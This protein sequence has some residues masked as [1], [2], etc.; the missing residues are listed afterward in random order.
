M[1]K[2]MRYRKRYDKKKGPK[3][4]SRN[5]SKDANAIVHQGYTVSKIEGVAHYLYS[6]AGMTRSQEW[7]LDS[8]ASTPMTGGEKL[9]CDWEPMKAVTVT[10]TVGDRF[11]DAAIGSATFSGMQGTVTFTG[12]LFVPGQYKNLISV[13]KLIEKRLSLTMIKSKCLLKS[14]RGLVMEAKK[15]GSFYSTECLEVVMDHNAPETV[16]KDK[17][18]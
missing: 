9:L 1:P 12:V 13:P 8:G 16:K 10:V 4:P 18:R 5:L 3:S 17:R 15:S 14:K 6:A 11:T 2:W 7:I